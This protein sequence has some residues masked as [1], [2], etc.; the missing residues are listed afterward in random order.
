MRQI[1]KGKKGTT[2]WCDKDFLEIYA[3][4]HHGIKDLTLMYGS[5]LTNTRDSKYGGFQYVGE[6]IREIP[7][8]LTISSYQ[9]DWLTVANDFGTSVKQLLDMRWPN[10]LVVSNSEI[11]EGSFRIE[12]PGYDALEYEGI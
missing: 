8:T 10:M 9:Y 11:C 2:L 7:I 3:D 1:V 12:I 4:I 6:L 5:N